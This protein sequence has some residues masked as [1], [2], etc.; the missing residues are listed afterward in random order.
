M[1]YQITKDGIEILSAKEV[2]DN[3][4]NGTATAQGMKEI[5]GQDT[6]FDQDSPDAQLVNIFAQCIRD[7]S[8][9]IVQVFNSFDPDQASGSVLDSRVLYNGVI[10]KGG[11]YTQVGITIV[12][13]R[14]VI[15]EG[16]DQ[17]SEDEINEDNVFTIQ[18]YNGNKY[19][20]LNTTT[21]KT[22][23]NADIVFRAQY[24]GEVWYL[25]NSINEIVTYK[26]GV[27]SVNNPDA[28]LMTGVAEETDEQLKIRRSRAVGLGMLGSVEVLQAS[29]RQLT[30]VVDAVVFENN[31]DYDTEDGIPPHSVWIIV[32]GG[33]LKDIANVIYLR[34]NAGCGMKGDTTVPVTTIFGDTFDVSFDVAVPENLSIR[35]HVAAV[36]GVD[37][38]D[39]KIL[40]DYI[41]YNYNF[42]IYEPAT[43][44]RIDAV[45]KNFS[46]K[47]SYSGIEISAD[48]NTRGKIVT[49][50]TLSLTDW[51]NVTYGC[52]NVTLDG[53]ETYQINGMNFSEVTS[54]VE[55]AN[56]ITNAFKNANYPA[57]AEAD[58]TTIT[59]Y[60][61]TRG[62]SS[63]IT[64]NE[65]SGSYED[66]SGSSYLDSE[67]MTYVTGTDATRGY[68][69]CNT[70]DVSQITALKAVTN[71]SFG[72]IVNN[73]TTQQI[74]GLNFSN[75]ETAEDVATIINSALASVPN[76]NA[77]AD[78][79]GL[80]VYIYSNTYGST[81][82]IEIVAGTSGTNVVTAS[83]LINPTETSVA[84]ING[85]NGT[86]T[87]SG[88]TLLNWQSVSN[89]AIA[90]K[91]NG[92]ASKSIGELDFRDCDT[93]TKVAT[94]LNSAFATNGVIATVTA[95][96]DEL[97]FTSNVAGSNS[98]IE[99]VQ[100]TGSF[101]DISGASLLD[102]LTMVATSGVSPQ[103]L[104]WT[105]L[106]YPVAKKNYFV[107][108]SSY[109]SVT[110]D[111]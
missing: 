14:N 89:G 39:P 104:S 94:L 95:D 29:L 42:N 66:L 41:A 70:M 20:L 75:I 10:R 26:R 71:G 7:L 40:A 84:G 98:T 85:T 15:I 51:Q 67:N 25:V 92:S 72:I 106:I 21:L 90:I 11:T 35:L 61:N 56:I 47:F 77:S 58:S 48:P 1:A 57:Y 36:N 78:N 3:I 107:I 55:I 5:F 44:T 46:D 23:T 65:I 73:G 81:S 74:S 22:G 32:R 80:N 50:D 97:V 64:V 34:L 111:D 68:I 54:F 6:N 101:T 103:E 79:T 82:N 33:T 12:A 45:C 37:V 49:T 102:R 88:F 53:S 27:I 9:C 59:I 16:I 83:L 91:V 13:D 19:Y 24:M 76:L 18:D 8:E 60:S 30:D 86:A 105:S 100:Y 87:T 99:F 28:P 31:T 108:D 43:S 2:A 62:S 69:T 52:L 109:I 4:I 38:I 63:S 17:K 93:I 96:N 110:V